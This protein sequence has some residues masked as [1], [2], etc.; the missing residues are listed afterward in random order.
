MTTKAA[1][2]MSV[3]NV[4]FPFNETVYLRASNRFHPFED[5]IAN[6]MTMITASNEGKQT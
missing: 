6:V 5:G 4:L 2:D 1:L 3:T